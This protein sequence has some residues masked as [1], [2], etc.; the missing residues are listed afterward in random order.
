[1]LR[2]CR[3]QFLTLDGEFSLEP[4]FRFRKFRESSNIKDPPRIVKGTAECIIVLKL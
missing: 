4:E 2:A 1:M 3:F